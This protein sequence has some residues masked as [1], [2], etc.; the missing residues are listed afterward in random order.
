MAYEKPQHKKF[1]CLNGIYHGTYLDDR[2]FRL[3]Q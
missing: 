1:N 2:V 3:R